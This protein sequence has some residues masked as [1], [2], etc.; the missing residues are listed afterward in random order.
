ML[1]RTR[2]L[3]RE[4]RAGVAWPMTGVLRIGGASG[5]W[6]DSIEGPVQLAR[7]G[8][9]DVLSFDY[10]AEL[11][12]SLLARA[13]AKDPKA[14]WATDFVDGAMRAILPEVARQKLRVVSN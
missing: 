8:A 3:R 14:G 9:V 1:A 6:G 10:L 2:G 11:T 12:M 7:S 13:R 4:A 5:A